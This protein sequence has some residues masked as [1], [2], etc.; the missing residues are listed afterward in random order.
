MK[1]LF[2]S[3]LISFIFAG[4]YSQDFQVPAN[5]VLDK[6]EDYS[7]YENEIIQ[8]CNWVISTPINEQAEK[9]KEVNGF[10]LKWLTGCPYLSL[11]IKTE[12]MNFMKPNPDLLMIFMAGWTRYSLETKDFNNKVNGNLK[13]IESVIE[14]YLKNKGDLKR[15]KNVEKYIEM[16]ESGS[17]EEYIK[18][19]A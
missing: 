17:L 16:K 6:A 9:R 15:D 12:I 2:L 18:A 7:K 10:I 5:Y 13:G 19:N 4:L 3:L 1:K 8:A 11:E 14:F